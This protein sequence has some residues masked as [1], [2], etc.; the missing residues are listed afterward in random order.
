M[1]ASDDDDD[2]DE[3]S[4]HVSLH[5]WYVLPYWKGGASGPNQ[6]ADR[7][8]KCVRREE[9]RVQLPFTVARQVDRVERGAPRTYRDDLLLVVLKLLP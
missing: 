8:S 3:P 4:V 1:L 5:R 7:Q 9:R 6:T 2:D